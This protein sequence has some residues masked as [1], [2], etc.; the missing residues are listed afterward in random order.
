MKKLVLLMALFLGVGSA[1]ATCPIKQQPCKTPCAQEKPCQK[2]CDK[3]CDKPSLV[4]TVEDCMDSSPCKACCEE[5]FHKKYMEMC[6]KLCLT[7]AQQCKADELYNCMKTELKPIKDRARC[8]QEKLCTMIEN[9]ACGA[10]IRTQKKCLKETKKEFKETMKNFDKEFRCI[11]DKC[12]LKEYK[13]MR[14]AEKRKMKKFAD[15]CP[16]Y[17]YECSK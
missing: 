17:L 11:L 3:P 1:F 12:Q 10:D 16:C 13:K 6:R 2:P 15:N 14:R 5:Y 9:D 8:E 7:K 4:K